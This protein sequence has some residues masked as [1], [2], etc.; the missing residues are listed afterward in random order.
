MPLAPVAASHRVV[1]P[2][3]PAQIGPPPCAATRPRDP[4][5]SPRR[6]GA[7]DGAPA[8]APDFDMVFQTGRS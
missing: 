4:G 2:D 5:P 1:A 7:L 3:L 6:A 8:P